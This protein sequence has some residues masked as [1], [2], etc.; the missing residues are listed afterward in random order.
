MTARSRDLQELIDLSHA[1]FDAAVTEPASR[2]SINA[3]FTALK[4][5]AAERAGEGT[6]LPVYDHLGPAL[7]IAGRTRPD[8]KPLAEAFRTVAPR[9]DWGRRATWDDT[10]SANFPDGHANAMIAGPRG[11]EHRTDAWLG[12]SL[13]APNVR[14]P[15]HTHAPEE[16]YLVLC[17]SEFRHGDS[18]WF[19][20]G[21]GGSFY[22]V[23]NIRH[24][25]RSLD[26]P[27]FAFWA[28]L[29]A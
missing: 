8:L 11:L 9:L 6:R 17:E 1:A 14:Y 21:V 24:A 3:I 15:D 26:A 22:N 28:L 4:Q 10:A 16:T 2:R 19:V 23:P 18:D 7:D 13:L 20:P 12:V 29:P 27:L 5:P 25:M